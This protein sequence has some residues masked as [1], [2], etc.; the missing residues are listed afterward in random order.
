MFVSFSV[1]V[2][3]FWAFIAAFLPGAIISFSLFRNVASGSPDTSMLA[4]RSPR[5]DEL[6]ALEKLLTGFA[7]GMVGLPLIPFLLYFV[8]G[9]KFSYAI[10][11]LSV[12]ALYAVAI[13]LFVKN[14]VYESIRLPEGGISIKLPSRGEEL[15][16]SL[17]SVKPSTLIAAGLVIVLVLTYL[18]RIGSYSP[19][20]QEL[21]PYYYTYVAHQIL[22]VG[23]N[24]LNDSSAWYPEIAADHREIPEISYLES[25][26]YSFYSGGAAYNDD[27]MHLALVASMYPPIA[28]VL[29]VFFIYL[30]V[31]TSS[32]RE[33]GVMAAGMASFIPVFV[34]KLAAGEQEV[35][36]YAFFALFFFYAMYALAI[37]RKDLRF[38]VIAGLA[39]AAV[40]LG[41]SSQ[42]L[43]LS[44]AMIF[45]VGQS[46]MCFLRDS[47]GS[48]LRQLLTLNAV[49]FVIGPLI[50]S[51]I[52]K[53][54]FANGSPSLF[55]VVP[56]LLCLALVAVLYA[57]KQKLPDRS[58]A[59][60]ALAAI[61]V[62]GLLVFAAT[63]LGDM[64]KQ[65]AEAGFS[66]AQYNAPLDRTIAEQGGASTAF[67]SQLGI[68]AAVFNQPGSSG[69]NMFSQLFG[70]ILWLV[71]LPF[72]AVANIILSISVSFLN[73]VL[74]TGVSIAPLDNSI[75]LFWIIAFMASLAWSLWK[76]SK[77]EEDALF[78]LFMAIVMPPFIVGIVKAKY[79]IYAGVMLA[80]AIGFTLEP[81][82]KFVAWLSEWL[83]KEPNRELMKKQAYYLMLI[84]GAVLVILQFAYANFASSLATSSLQPLYQNDPMALASKFK[85][86]CSTSNDSVVCA[87]A[88]DPPGYAAKG[89]NYQYSYELCLASVYSNF[90][91]LSNPGAAPSWEPQAA[92]FRCQRISDYWIDSM[93]WLRYNTPN[94]SR[95]VS[96]W[97]YGHWINYFGLRNA[98]IR[99]EHLSHEMIGEVAHDYIDGTPQDLISFMKSHDIRY[100]LFDMELI[101]GGG[102]L[103]GKYGALNYLSCARD[104]QTDVSKAP[105]SSQCEANHL[106][107]TIFISSQPC[108]ISSISNR[109]G[110]IAYEMYQ[111]I[112]TAGA[113]GRPVFVGTF[114]S[115]TYL[116][117][118]VNPTDANVISYC[119]NAVKAVPTY[120]VG[121][122]T[123][124]N[125]QQ[126]YAPYYLNQTY[127]NGDLKLNKA[128]L[129]LPYQLQNSYHFGPATA[130]TLLYT[131]DAIWLENGEL[132][133]G[134][135]DRKGLF[136]SS[137]LYRALFLNEI[138]GF[139]L[140]YSTP[141]NAVKIYELEG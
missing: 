75:M 109:S 4:A 95:I 52:L 18:V 130:A 67:D 32:R 112:Y 102:Q 115:P 25:I 131:N 59:T 74:G 129:Q 48:E 78:L 105:G 58:N 133:S 106:W 103:G 46:V 77:K 141:D 61:V 60:M 38:A 11:L 91:Y 125:G 88:A 29:A 92:Y 2:F 34:Y 137:N 71:F 68:I 97:D 121:Q 24:P 27:N 21:D 66:I 134:Y 30:L 120:C 85:A 6:N 81:A 14:K 33:W 126:T 28:A 72:T 70:Y 36:P 12:A 69:Q 43:A 56:C 9:V 51:S 50:G 89:T 117:D 54:V 93:E 45:M 100:A 128:L 136:Y 53:D 8:L 138:P 101:S 111:D 119:K 82:S 127:P 10:A 15:V 37:S 135:E 99:N 57:L 84:I 124:A 16:N 114:Y 83:S 104:N 3:L 19:V 80:V 49:V 5:Q 55:I 41:S 139:K 35:Q 98:V 39:F 94:G 140:V 13:A 73:F 47:D 42:V 96:W 64:V 79:T 90:T 1:P 76:F 63:P 22:S 116:P 132:K 44:V 26:W 65:V 31:S 87:A 23:Y 123:L 17:L 7:I 20:F 110:V 118:C 113:D 107:E 122:A 40:C 108:T 62:V 86:F